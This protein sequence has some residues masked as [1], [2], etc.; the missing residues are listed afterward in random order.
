M[1]EL[2]VICDRSKEKLITVPPNILKMINL[3]ML[4]LEGNFI[5]TLPDD[6]FWKLPGLKW[7]DLRNNMLES[8]PL[9]IA[10][11]KCLENI[12]LTNNNLHKLPNEL[13][14]VKSLKGLHITEN[15]LVY[16]VRAILAAGT[17]IIKDFLREQYEITHIKNESGEESSISDGDIQDTERVIRVT[18]IESGNLDKHYPSSSKMYNEARK[19]MDEI[20]KTISDEQTYNPDLKVKQLL[21]P[22]LSKDKK[23]P[24]KVK[25]IHKVSRTGSTLYLKSYFNKT[26]KDGDSK[27]FNNLKEG[28]LKELRNLLTDQERIIQQ[29]RNLQAITTWRLKMKSEA[30]IHPKPFLEGIPQAPYGTDQ[31]YAKTLSR[32]ELAKK[33]DEE[34]YVSSEPVVHY[35]PVDIQM[36]ITNLM[37][38]LKDMKVSFDPVTPGSGAEQAEKQ[39]KMIMDIQKKLMELKSINEKTL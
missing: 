7:L 25:I 1:Y 22:N 21:S 12:L 29:E 17:E 9:S 11:H 3:K 24:E 10:F 28:W 26:L 38:Q 39:I 16:P 34:S 5:T 6:I 15:P 31:R 8:I 4:F 35:S 18:N 32:E 2:D 23:D 33:F 37:E 20:K 14:T 27:K 19:S 30:K 36:M 13:G